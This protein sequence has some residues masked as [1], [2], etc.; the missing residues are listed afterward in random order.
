MERL[1]MRKIKEVLRLKYENA[2]SDSKIAVSCCIARSTVADYISRAKQA[3]LTWPIPLDID[4]TGLEMHI[5]LKTGTC[6]TPNRSPV[7][8]KTGTPIGAERRWLFITYT[9]TPS[10]HVKPFFV[11]SW[12]PR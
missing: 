6:F 5:S 9:I 12:T 1:T 8:I 11:F 10:Y 2:L 7:S 3:G 4:E